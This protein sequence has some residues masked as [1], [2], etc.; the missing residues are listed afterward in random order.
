MR[1]VIAEDE[2]IIALGLAS[3]LK[4]LG[5]DV[6]SLCSS[7][8]RCIELVEAER[9]DVVFMDI[10]MDGPMD[11]IEAAAVVKARFGTPVIFTTAFD[12][13][14]TRERAAEVSPAAF[15][16]KPVGG[17]SIRGAMAK[18]DVAAVPKAL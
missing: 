1:V 3:L 12:D 14:H 5:H 15:L 13:R 8:E 7:G 6:R 10:R 9:P 18:I 16:T 2:R 11:G 17:D 4:K